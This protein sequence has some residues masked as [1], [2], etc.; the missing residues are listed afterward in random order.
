MVLKET[1]GIFMLLFALELIS[2]SFVPLQQHV[3]HHSS[4]IGAR[5]GITA[6]LLMA[7]TLRPFC[8]ESICSFLPNALMCGIGNPV[9]YSRATVHHGEIRCRHLLSLIFGSFVLFTRAIR[10][11]LLYCVAYVNRFPEQPRALKL[12]LVAFSSTSPNA[13]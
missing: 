10:N 7:I 11:T 2:H 3:I 8:V 12:S 6:C 13:P 4:L 9:R 1:N 5:W